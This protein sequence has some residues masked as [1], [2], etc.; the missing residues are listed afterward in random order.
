MKTACGSVMRLV[1]VVLSDPKDRRDQGPS[2]D[3]VQ[4]TDMDGVEDW[5][6]IA[7]GTDAIDETDI[8]VPVMMGLPT[9]YR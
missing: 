7:V 1:Y 5:I 3:L 9:S 6:E 4:D 8:P 2:L